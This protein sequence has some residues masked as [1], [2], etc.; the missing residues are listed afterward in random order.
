MASYCVYLFIFFFLFKRCN[1]KKENLAG[2]AKQS[3]PPKSSHCED[4]KNPKNLFN[5]PQEIL[6]FAQYDVT[7][8]HSE[9]VVRRISCCTAYNAASNQHLLK[10]YILLPSFCSAW[11]VCLSFTS[12]GSCS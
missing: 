5:I 10:S 1:A 9:D 11:Q 7:F 12:F 3:A 4:L 8:G 2:Q 6:R